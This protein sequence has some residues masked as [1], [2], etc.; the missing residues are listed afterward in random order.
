M[1]CVMKALLG[2]VVM[3]LA[4][5]SLSQPASAQ[6][7]SVATARTAGKNFHAFPSVSR[8]PALPPD[9]G[10]LVYHTGGPVMQTGVTPFVIF[11][12]PTKLQS[13]ATATP[14][15]AHYQTVQKNLLRDY[16]AHG[17][18]NINTQYYQVINGVKSYIQ[19]KGGALTAYVD[20]N[21]YPASGCTDTATPKNCITD[22]QLI[23]EIANVMALNGWTGGMNKIYFVYTLKGE[24]SCFDSTSAQCAYTYYCAYHSYFT[25]GTTPVIYA[26]QP[27]GDAA[28]CQVPGT[29]SPNNDIPADTAASTASH[30]MSEAITDPL[31]NAWYTPAGSENGDLCA[32][33]YGL[34]YNWDAGKANQMW[35]GHFYMLQQEYNNNLL[36]CDQVG[37]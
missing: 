2:A 34:F 31:L 19:N 9:S 3:L 28:H 10:P 16:P 11:W 15:T 21:P 20:T 17:L 35:N 27:F 32:Y 30:E 1:K 6:E 12:T 29:P 22:A 33:D 14:M 23:N 36:E 7:A 26:N 13:G 5:G 18:D 25:I 4:A 37:P 8:R 24:G